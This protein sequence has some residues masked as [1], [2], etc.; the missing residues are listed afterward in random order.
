MKSL[1]QAV[2]DPW[3]FICPIGHNGKTELCPI[4]SRN[5]DAVT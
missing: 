5:D 2:T 4:K 1:P 3:T